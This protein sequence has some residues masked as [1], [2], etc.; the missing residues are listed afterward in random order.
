[1]VL[2]N[3]TSNN[4]KKSTTTRSDSSSGSSYNTQSAPTRSSAP[5]VAPAGTSV[6]DGKFEFQV[7]GTSRGETSKQDTF[8]T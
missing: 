3:L 1:M 6:R 7:L 2:G 4:D 8:N 5:S